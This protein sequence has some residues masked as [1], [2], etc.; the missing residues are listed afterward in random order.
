MSWFGLV[1]GGATSH[2]ARQ[3]GTPSQIRRCQLPAPSNAPT[4]TST[5]QTR[6]A[7]WGPESLPRPQAEAGTQA[8]RHQAHHRSAHAVA[9]GARSCGA[10]TAPWIFLPTCPLVT[11]RKSVRPATIQIHGSVRIRS[12]TLQKTN[13]KPLII[14]QSRCINSNT[15]AP[16]SE[17]E[18]A[19]K[20]SGGWFVLWSGPSSRLVPANSRSL[21]LSVI[22][23]LFG[24]GGL[25]GTSPV[26]V[27]S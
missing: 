18:R 22:A 17:A 15:L 7:Q 8:R 26:R 4:D 9:R 5:S 3:Y 14:G 19:G 11:Q 12:R 21:S 6:R 23:P 20:W 24:G 13:T 25:D 1:S 16:K 10:T 2:N 27:G